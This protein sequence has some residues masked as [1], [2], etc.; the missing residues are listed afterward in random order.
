MKKLLTA[1]A[2]A[3]LMTAPAL[4]AGKPCRDAK[5]HFAA[6]PAGAAAASADVKKGADGKCRWT[7]TTKDHKAGTFAKC[8]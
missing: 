6:C 2:I 1:F 4:A 5:G 7:K 8:P 3:G